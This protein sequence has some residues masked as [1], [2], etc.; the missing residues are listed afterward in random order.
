M[1]TAQAQQVPVGTFFGLPG[2]TETFE[3]YENL[4]GIVTALA[5]G[6][7]T[8]WNPPG[9]LQKTDIVKWWEMETIVSWTTTVTGSTIS[10]GAPYNLHQNLKLRLQGQYSPL[11]VESGEDAGFFQM[12]RPMRGPG[13]QSIQT[14]NGTNL[15]DIYANTTMPQTNQ[16]TSGIVANPASGS[17]WVWNLEIPAGIYI[18]QYWDMAIDGTLLPNAYGAVAPI[19]AWVSPQYMGGGERVVVPTF[20]YA[21]ITAANSDQGPLTGST[22]GAASVTQNMRR[23]GYYG[24]KDPSGLPPVFNWQY[25]RASK[26]YPIGAA[27]KIDIP[28]T[29]YGQLFSVFIRIYDP[30]AGTFYNVANISKAQLLKGSNLPKYDDDV[31]TMQQRFIYQH[32]FV[33]PQGIV[34]WDMLANTSAEGLSND[35]RVLNTLTNANTHVH[36]EMSPAPNATAYAVIGTELLVPVATQ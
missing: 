8:P 34:A 7:Q 25:R 16:T 3:Q 35:M 6:A 29:E 22:A 31:L 23:V 24:S 30:T 33:P 4:N 18:D 21:A 15:A 17:T 26:R 19:G 2:V 5:L 36:L 9:S 14:L 13:Q 10:P 32:G 11:E 1:V 12:Y 27:T 28:V 20:N